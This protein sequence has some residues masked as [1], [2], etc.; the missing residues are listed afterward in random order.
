MGS[1]FKNGLIWGRIW[2]GTLRLLWMNMIKLNFWLWAMFARNT[3]LLN[4][5]DSVHTG[6]WLHYLCWF[7]WTPPKE[8]LRLTSFSTKTRPIPVAWRLPACNDSNVINCL[9]LSHQ[10][11]PRSYA[12]YQT[13]KWILELLT[14]AK[15][16]KRL[17]W[18]IGHAAT[19]KLKHHVISL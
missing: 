6:A 12:S 9:Y 3:H 5:Q 19:S 2:K 18:A 13:S 7:L 8:S 11:K 14:R 17:N 15:K 4:T 16:N 10:N 1:A